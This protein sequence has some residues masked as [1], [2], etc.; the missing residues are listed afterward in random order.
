VTD[1]DVRLSEHRSRRPTVVA[2]CAFGLF[3]AT[4]LAVA[5]GASDRIDAAAMTAIQNGTASM[6]LERGWKREAL[7][8]WTALG[9]A[10]VLIG[11]VGCVAMM[12]IA[13]GRLRLALLIM[14]SG[15][16]ATAASTGIKLAL[17]RARPD[18]LGNPVATFTASFPSGHA[19]LTAAIFLPLAVLA[20]RRQKRSVTRA[21]IISIGVFL[22]ATIGLTRLVLGV[23]WPSDILA[24]WSF[25][26]AWAALTILIMDRLAL[27]NARD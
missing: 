6:G 27:G 9:G 22:V 11:L 17:A 25:G 24:G 23:H 7:R 13:G 21:V 4:A 12:M 16:G 19:L 14:W 10:S 26:V 18:I 20:A 3:L 15:L 1:E 8:D 5:G 2:A